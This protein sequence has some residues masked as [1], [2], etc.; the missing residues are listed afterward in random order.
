MVRAIKQARLSIDLAIY[1]LDLWAVRDALLDA[2]HRGLQVRMVTDTDSLANPE[3]QELISA[4]IPVVDN[5][6]VSL[7]HNK[8]LVLDRQEVWTGS[9]NLTVNSA[10]R[11]NENMVRVDSPHLAENYL[12]EFEEMFSAGQFGPGSPANT[13]YSLLTISNTQVETYFSPD[14]GIEQRIL[15]LIGTAQ[16]NISFLA[17]SFTSDAIADAMLARAK[18]GVS[19]SGVFD[20][21]QVNSNEGTEYPRLS[22]AGLNVRLDGNPKYMHDKVIVIDGQTV[23]TGSYN[24]SNSAE[25]KNDENIL[26][27]H[28]SQIAAQFLQEFQDIY[29]H[30]Q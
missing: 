11:N 3:I 8:F 17:F 26:V 27:I 5:R 30:T 16:E 20:A 28:D 14:D 24:F 1:D 2:Q 4:G 19:V 29:N 6:Q 10:Y 23:I 9:M 22:Q 18:E 7:M 15:E 25:T 12:T 13:P 21:G